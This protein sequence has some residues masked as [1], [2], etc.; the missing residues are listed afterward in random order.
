MKNF[1]IVFLAIRQYCHE[2]EPPRRDFFEALQKELDI[3]ESAFKVSLEI[4][5]NMKLIQYSLDEEK[6]ISLTALGK[7]MERI[8]SS[9]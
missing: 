8:A 1:N 4:L 5:K 3:N 6:D 9:L 2:I 7:Q